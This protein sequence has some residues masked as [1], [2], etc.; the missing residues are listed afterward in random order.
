MPDS[1]QEEEHDQVQ[2]NRYQYRT[3]PS[4]QTELLTSFPFM[5]QY[6]RFVLCFVLRIVMSKSCDVGS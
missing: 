1:D 4:D 2:F 5:G 3:L 6:V